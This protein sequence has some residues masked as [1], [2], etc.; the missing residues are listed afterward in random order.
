MDDNIDRRKA[1]RQ[2]NPKHLLLSIYIYSMITIS[3]IAV[4]TWGVWSLYPYKTIEYGNQPFKI[5]SN[6]IVKQGE[7]ITYTVEYTKSTKVIPTQYKQFVDGIIYNIPAEEARPVIIDPGSGVAFINITVP[8]NLPP[9]EYYL[10]TDTY[11]KMNPVRTIQK[12]SRTETFTV[13]AAGHGDE[14]FDKK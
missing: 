7:S 8:K 2:L 12:E 6:R 13:I 10:H 5:I 11:Y 4:F 1:K 3:A 14:E 9:G